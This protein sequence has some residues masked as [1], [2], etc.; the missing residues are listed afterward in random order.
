MLE[1]GVIIVQLLEFL[2]YQFYIVG[3][4]EVYI[5][6]LFFLIF[7]FSAL[8]ISLSS[9]EISLSRISWLSCSPLLFFIIVNNYIFKALYSTSFLIC[10]YDR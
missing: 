10:L 8:V 2:I 3:V 5:Q 4:F 9:T 7:I 6:L 1:T